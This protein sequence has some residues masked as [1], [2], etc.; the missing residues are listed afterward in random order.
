MRHLL[1]ILLLSA[2]LAAC[3][4]STT[5]PTPVKYPHGAVVTITKLDYS[6]SLYGGEKFKVKWEYDSP[7][8]LGADVTRYL[9]GNIDTT[10]R[11]NNVSPGYGV[12]ALK[13]SA[14]IV[15]ACKMPV[16]IHRNFP[17]S[18]TLTYRYADSIVIYASAAPASALS[19]QY[20]GHAKVVTHCP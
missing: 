13:D 19:S 6:D 20:D 1:A 14:Y 3:D 8:Y 9:G 17:V 11:V 16:V 10:Y 7:L 2:L 4:D 15:S 5:A 18:D 12:T